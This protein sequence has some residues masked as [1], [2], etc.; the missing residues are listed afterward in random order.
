[1]IS[2]AFEVADKLV[3]S[4]LAKMKLPL[5]KAWAAAAF[6][7]IGTTCFSIIGLLL[8]A[9]SEEFIPTAP[10][11]L[12]LA[13]VLIHFLSMLVAI[14]LSASSAQDSAVMAWWRSMPVS[15]R[16]LGLGWSIPSWVLTLAQLVIVVPALLTVFG[17]VADP[18]LIVFVA[19]CAV[20]VGTVAGRAAFVVAR[21]VLRRISVNFAAHAQ[22]LGTLAWVLSLAGATE[23]VRLTLTASGE[24]QFPL[25]SLLGYPVLV[26]ASVRHS[27]LD[28]GILVAWLLAAA[29]VETVLWRHF[30]LVR[31][32][33]SRVLRLGTAFTGKERFPLLRLEFTRLARRRRVQAAVLSTLVIQAALALVH[34]NMDSGLRASFLDNALLVNAILVA[35]AP[36]LARGMSNRSTPYARVMGRSPGSWALAVTF[37]GML[38]ALFTA[39]PAL[40]FWSIGSGNPGIFGA[41]LGLATF[42]GVTA[43]ITGFVLTPGDETGA[44]ESLGM[45]IVGASLFLVAKAL[46]SVGFDNVLTAGPAMGVL[47][48]G[49]ICIP[50]LIESFRWGDRGTTNEPSAAVQK[51]IDLQERK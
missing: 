12:G 18:A 15:D 16:A 29:A 25:A 13:L 8:L 24:N 43:A 6:L 39:A 10:A 7:A 27:A 26:T 14:T 34:Q 4:W 30:A 40:V 23:V 22:A 50:S 42:T 11:F 1:M 28:V 35:Y 46:T 19:S 33:P 41:G 3:Q 44:G 21:T 45:L 5:R 51:S 17:G 48:V 20:F 2:E 37:S 32:D 38:M 31:H 9:G 36:L 49:M 47:A